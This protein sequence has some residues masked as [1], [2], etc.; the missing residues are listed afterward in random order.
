MTTSRDEQK[1]ATREAILEAARQC[2]EVEGYE[3][4]SVRDI[5]RAAGVSAGSVIHHFGSKRELLYATL[6]ED[7]EAT[8]SEALS[9]GTSPPLAGQI[10][11][12]TRHI[13]ACYGRRPRL[14][15][16]LL[17]ESLFAEEP[18]ASRF[19]AQTE[20]LHGGVEGLAGDAVRRGELLPEV[21]T[22]LLAM[23]YV[24]FYYFALL[25]WAQGGHEDPTRLVSVQMAQHLRGLNSARTTG[26]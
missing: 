8:M 15:R 20:R 14:S 23:A 25:A 11:A 9:L 3:K 19:R 22:R 13:F 17:K 10:E 5:A 18:W 2:F 1:K 4:A 26:G 24:S 6:F 21:D 12:M 7:L 16:V